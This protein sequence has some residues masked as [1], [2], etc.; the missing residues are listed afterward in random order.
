MDWLWNNKKQIGQ[1]NVEYVQPHNKYEQFLIDFIQHEPKTNCQP[2]IEYVVIVKLIF[3]LR[4]KLTLVDNIL[5]RRFLAHF[6]ILVG[7][8]IFSSLTNRIITRINLLP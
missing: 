1:V 5:A 7:R 6:I 2:I 3:V 8:V 4:M